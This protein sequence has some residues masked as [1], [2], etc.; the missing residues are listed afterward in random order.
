M[1][2]FASVG[3]TL[4]MAGLGLAFPESQVLDV[5]SRVWGLAYLV[6][7]F[8]SSGKLQIQH[9]KERF[10]TDY[11]RKKWGQPLL[12]AV[13]VMSVFLGALV[14]LAFLSVD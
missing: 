1:W 7:W 12:I 4:A 6:V 13:V 5:L 3:L 11:E 10:G 14:G 9:V 8:T 2:F